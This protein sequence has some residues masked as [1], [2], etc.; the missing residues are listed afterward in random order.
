MISAVISDFKTVI[1]L[2]SVRDFTRALPLDNS[3][4]ITIVMIGMYDCQEPIKI[5]SNL[6]S[7]H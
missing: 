5:R 7:F 6:H 4:S 1:S 3:L 2:D